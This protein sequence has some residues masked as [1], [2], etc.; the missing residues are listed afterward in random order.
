MNSLHVLAEAEKGDR[1]VC[2][3]PEP[4][5]IPSWPLVPLLASTHFCL[6]VLLRGAVL[7]LQS[8]REVLICD[9]CALLRLF[10]LAAEQLPSGTDAPQ[11]LDDCIVALG[12]AGL[13]RMLAPSQST[14]SQQSELNSLA[15]LGSRLGRSAQS[16][17]PAF[18]LWAETAHLLGLLHNAS[19]I[20]VIMGW[21][22]PAASPAEASFLTARLARQY[23]VPAPLQRAMLDLAIDS[24]ASVWIPLMK[25]AAQQVAAQRAQTRL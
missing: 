3:S 4:V 19:E 13:R 23:A 12:R 24:Q 2:S 14:W 6:E 16:L 8:T 11:H 20:P 1:T 10:A 17:A 25:A 18:A 5:V 22:P 9:P 21:C 7:D 15:E